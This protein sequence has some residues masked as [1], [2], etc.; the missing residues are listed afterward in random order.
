M[1]I[2]T[3]GRDVHHH[4]QRTPWGQKVW[5]WI[6][7]D[8]YLDS[9]FCFKQTHIGFLLNSTWN[10]FERFY[11]PAKYRKKPLLNKSLYPI[12]SQDFWLNHFLGGCP[13]KGWDIFPP[14][15]WAPDSLHLLLVLQATSE[16]VHCQEAVDG[17]KSGE[18]TSKMYKTS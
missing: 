14:V 11:Y 7:S 12:P 15:P 2:Q 13:L 9:S 5:S 6:L 18:I 17:W 8:T 16:L 1:T 4:K 3:M 10:I